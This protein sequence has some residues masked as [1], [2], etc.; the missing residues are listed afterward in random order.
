MPYLEWRY[1]LRPDNPYRIVSLREHS[2][3]QLRACAIVRDCPFSPDVTLVLEWFVLPADDLAMDALLHV[4]ERNG[5]E[6]GRSNL[7]FFAPPGTSHRTPLLTRGFTAHPTPM[8]VAG[9]CWDP[10]IP[11][12]ELRERL[13]MSWETSTTCELLELPR[14]QKFGSRPCVGSRFRPRPTERRPEIRTMRNEHLASTLLLTVF[15]ITPAYTQRVQGDV[16]PSVRRAFDQAWNRLPR[17]WQEEAR[18]IKL[19]RKSAPDL[20]PSVRLPLEARLLLAGAHAL[21]STSEHQIEVF[22]AALG[23][24]PTWS[25]ERPSREELAAFLRGLADVLELG[26]ESRAVN[27]ASLSSA[28]RAFVTRVGSWP[29]APAHDL[30][31]EATPG[32]PA[33]LTGF[34]RAAVDR[35]LGGRVPPLEQLLVHELAHAVQLAPDDYAARMARWGTLSTWHT[36]RDERPADGLVGG[37]FRMEH[38][39]VL[40][41]G[42]LNG[43]RGP[44]AFYACASTARFANRYMEYDLREDFAEAVRLA[45]YEPHTLR[46]HAP[47]KLLAVNAVCAHAMNTASDHELLI[48]KEQLLSQTWQPAVTEGLR[49][50]VTPKPEEPAWDPRLAEQVLEAHRHVWQALPPT[51]LACLDTAKPLAID[52]PPFIAGTQ[53]TPAG[54]RVHGRVLAPPS[55]S[56][57]AMWDAAIKRFEQ[58]LEFEEGIWILLVDDRASAMSIVQ[59]EVRD[60]ADPFRRWLTWNTLWPHLKRT[61]ERPTLARLAREEA[62]HHRASGRRLLSEL[63]HE[64]AGLEIQDP[65]RPEERLQAPSWLRA[66]VEA[67]QLTWALQNEDSITR[68][69]LRRLRAIPGTC[70]GARARAQLAIRALARAEGMTR[71]ELQRIAREAIRAIPLPELRRRLQR[72]LDLAN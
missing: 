15:L 53:H 24:G 31:M 17:A 8:R 72:S 1:R 69:W 62:R 33:F 66:E 9:R 59:K 46:E 63:V 42:L 47:E 28:W 58:T 32:D 35:S 25:Q 45:L 6:R 30:N 22:D 56:Y 21:Y 48:A 70:W 3:Q 23:N 55:R 38:P 18:G 26:T 13:Y 14:H 2:T 68:N 19:V 54:V 61:L 43:S 27:D 49:R 5:K 50:I 44:A 51:A 34:L 29:E 40:I 71:G 60:Q 41:R 64:L 52:L 57:V 11:L 7:C 37:G 12:N 65:L 10:N 67:T 16:E 4:C 36:P 39:L 20:P